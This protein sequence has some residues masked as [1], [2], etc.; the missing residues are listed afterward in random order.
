MCVCVCVC[1]CVCACVCPRTRVCYCTI[2]YFNLS[3]FTPLTAPLL[4][5]HAPLLQ[6]NMHYQAEGEDPEEKADIIC[7][8]KSK[9]GKDL[10]AKARDL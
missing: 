5:T 1:V 8:L 10:V 2:I 9:T 3:S 4:Q 7:I 6:N